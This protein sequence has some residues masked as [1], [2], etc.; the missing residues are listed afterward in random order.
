MIPKSAEWIG[1]QADFDRIPSL[2]KI[3]AAG[4]LLLAHITSYGTE[5]AQKY[6]NVFDT[7]TVYAPISALISLNICLVLFVWHELPCREYASIYAVFL[8][9]GTETAQI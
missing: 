5:T 9:F 2:N 4:P 6:A 7:F 1:C 8:V 3:D